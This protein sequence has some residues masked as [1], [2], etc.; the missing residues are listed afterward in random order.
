[1]EKPLAFLTKTT[2]RFMFLRVS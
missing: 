1:V 2:K